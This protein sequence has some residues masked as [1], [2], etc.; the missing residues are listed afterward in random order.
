M[1]D[2]R[3]RGSS[4]KPFVKDVVSDLH[5]PDIEFLGWPSRRCIW[6]SLE[7]K[8]S[9]HSLRADTGYHVGAARAWFVK[10]F[11]GWKGHTDWFKHVSSNGAESA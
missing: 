6:G 11:T 10:L 9:T 3:E 5:A 4:P 2:F 1:S 8:L 7:R